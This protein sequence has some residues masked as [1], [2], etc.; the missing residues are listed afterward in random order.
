MCIQTP[1]EISSWLSKLS[2]DCILNKKETECMFSWVGSSSQILIKSPPNVCE[3][4]M[5]LLKTQGEVSVLWPPLGNWCQRRRDRKWVSIYWYCLTGI[6]SS[7]LTCAC[8]VVQSRLTLCDFMGWSPPASSVHGIF[9]GKDTGVGYYFLLQ[10]NFPTQGSDPRILHL[11][12][13]QADSLPLSHL[14]SPG[15]LISVCIFIQCRPVSSVS[16]GLNSLGLLNCFLQDDNH[17]LPSGSWI[18]HRQNPVPYI[19]LNVKQ[20]CV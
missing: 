20:E 8:S 16:A 3:I 4:Q 7:N 19:F 1:G 17:A 9:P 2:W 10:M 13:W 18:L 14:R 12:H 15:N 5:M 11:L 6:F